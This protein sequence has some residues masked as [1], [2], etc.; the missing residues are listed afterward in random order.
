MSKVFRATDFVPSFYGQEDYTVKEGLESGKLK[1]FVS[2]GLT[3]FDKPEYRA[4]I[5]N[6]IL[7]FRI[8]AKLAKKYLKGEE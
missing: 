8:E 5:G 7:T 2:K 1:V 6:S 4:Q 3:V